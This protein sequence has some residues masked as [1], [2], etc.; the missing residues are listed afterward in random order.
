MSIKKQPANMKLN[1]NQK[2]RVNSKDSRKFSDDLKVTKIVNVIKYINPINPTNQKP[3]RLIK[4]SSSCVFNNTEKEKN[5]INTLNNANTGSTSNLHLNLNNSNSNYYISSQINNNCDTST[6][7]INKKDSTINLPKKPKLCLMSST[8]YKTLREPIV[9]TG[10]EDSWMNNIGNKMISRDSYFSS[11][12]KRSNNFVLKRNFNFT[13]QK[14]FRKV[15][16]AEPSDNQKLTPMRKI[17]QFPKMS[18]EMK[19]LIKGLK[20][21]K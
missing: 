6:Y 7:N 20:L 4:T 3:T 10:K 2:I 1:L 17:N 14:F 21:E 11:L 9:N 18:P 12:E 5:S 8:S 15:N 13:N 19:K 16:K